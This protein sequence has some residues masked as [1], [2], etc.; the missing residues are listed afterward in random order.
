MM[1]RKKGFTLMELMIAILILALV[2]SLSIEVF[3]S[4]NYDYQKIAMYLNFYIKG[5]HALDVISKDCR[6]AIRIM[7]SYSGYTTS[8]T[9][10]VLKVPS[11]DSMKNIINI[12]KNFD[13]II[14]RSHNG[15]LWK[16]VIPGPG[17]SR[18]A[19]NKVFERSE[20]FNLSYNGAPVSSIA[21]KSTMPHIT[22]TI[23]VSQNV[24]GKVYSVT[25][26]TTVKLMNYE[27]GFVR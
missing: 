14:Y 18:A 13:Y 12:N 1:L 27:W 20:S 16:I 9:C 11:I 6:T 25:P 26:G 5:R 2:V 4:V 21:H 23:T 17:S 15:D 8:D 24:R 3:I 7:D 22:I 19:Q 10:L